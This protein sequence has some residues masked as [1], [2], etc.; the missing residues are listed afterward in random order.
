MT[1]AVEIDKLNF[2]YKSNPVLK[3]MSFCVQEG[4]FFIIIGPNGSGKTTLMKI[5]SGIIRFQKGRLNIFDRPAGEYTSR[6]LARK[7]AYVPQAPA[8]DFP[9]SVRELV[10]MG[11]S[12]YI[13]VLGIEGKRDS[14]FDFDFDGIGSAW[15]SASAFASASA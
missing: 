12:P 5:I 2:S 3:D 11:R 4:E 6:L 8:A 15:A 1:I 14:D 9:F 13:G 7:I 10:L